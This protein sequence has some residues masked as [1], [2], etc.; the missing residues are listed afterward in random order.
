MEL[1]DDIYEQHPISL[2]ISLT[3]GEQIVKWNKLRRE[4]HI[5]LEE[6]VKVFVNRISGMGKISSMR[7][8]KL[9]L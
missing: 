7:E 1:W 4:V 3:T 2:E 6:T 8:L 9:V 5:Y